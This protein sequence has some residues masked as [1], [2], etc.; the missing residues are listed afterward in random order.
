MPDSTSVPFQCVGIVGLGLM[1]GSLARSLKALG[2]PPIIRALS[3]DPLDL[4]GGLDAGVVDEA[5]GEPRDFFRDLELAVY[6]TPL[7]ATL[8]LLERHRAFLEPETI[9]T[10]VVSLKGPLLKQA[11]ALE[12]GGVF[13]GSHPMAGGEGR[14]FSASRAGLFRDAR[15]WIIP[16]SAPEERVGRIEELWRALGC[17]GKRT[18]AETHDA[19]MAWVSHLPQVTANALAFALKKEGIPRNQLGPGGRDMTR[20]AGS[21]SEMWKDLLR[22]APDALPEALEATERILSELRG[23]IGEGEARKIAEIMDQTRRW[24]EETTGEERE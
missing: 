7:E 2:A 21:S 8:R 4:K 17:R 16:G 6:C 19:L 15:V 12:L 10:D 23:S 20:L 22:H 11:E 24:V 18:D 5:P 13:V 14:G 9:I 3:R 1:G